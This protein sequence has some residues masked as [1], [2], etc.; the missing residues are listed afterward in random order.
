MGKR[1]MV[2]P[3]LLAAATAQAAG[4]AAP[5]ADP[6]KGQAIATTVC[7]ACHG[8]DGNSTAPANPKLAGQFPE[9]L[10]KQMRNF[11]AAGDKQPE[12]MNAI[13]NGMIA[14][15]ADDDLPH[16]AA[17]FATQ[18]LQPDS[19]KSKETLEA[20]RNIYRAGI[21]SKG[22]PACAG[23]HGPT[24]SGLPAQFPRI[25][26]QYGEYTEAQLRI[27]RAGER[28]NDPNSMMRTIADRMSDREIKAVSDYIAGL[29]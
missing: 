12:R 20:G 18:K 26:G 4:E 14:A 19:A 21:A 13:M 10:L 15:V 9:Y 7:A 8:P 28:A 16:V 29:R 24:G 2:V 6:A 27:F 17:Y 25:A 5:K 11:K 23:C 22:I 3:L 1:F